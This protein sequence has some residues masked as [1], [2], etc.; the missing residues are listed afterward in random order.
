MRETDDRLDGAIGDALRRLDHARPP[1]GADAVIRRARTRRAR[2]TPRLVAGAAGLVLATAAL[3]M[4]GS[5]VA[6]W[7]RHSVLGRRAA[8]RGAVLPAPIVPRTSTAASRSRI[9]VVPGAEF[10]L[11]FEAAQAVGSVRLIFGPAAELSVNAEGGETPYT[12]LPGGLAVGNR[13]SSASYAVHVPNGLRTLRVV[14]G[15][16]TVFARRNGRIAR[17]LATNAQGEYVLA[18]STRR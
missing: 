3:A 6:R 1:V 16:V 2:L 10:E 11:S 7:V 9:A 15:G 8:E 12:L 17:P 18:L 13:G 14:V 5:P 4:P